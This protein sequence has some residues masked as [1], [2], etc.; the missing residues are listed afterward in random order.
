MTGGGI[1]RLQG[2]EREIANWDQVLDLPLIHWVTSGKLINPFSP[3]NPY[4]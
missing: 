2:G 3:Q 1:G 4:L